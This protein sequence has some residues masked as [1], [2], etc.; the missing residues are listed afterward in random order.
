MRKK[1]NILF[2]CVGRR[3]E[4]LQAFIEAGQKLNIDLKIYGTDYSLT[5]PAL[6][7]CDERIQICRIS[8]K[9]YIPNL[10]NICK[11]KEIDLVIPTIDT[12]LLI[13]AQEKE[14]FLHINTK[15]LVSSVDKIKICRDKRDTAKFFIDC[16]LLTPVPVDDITNY[17]SGF[18]CFIKPLNGSSSINAYKV[19][20]NE[21]LL[22]YVT[23]VDDYII[24]PYIG[25]IEYTVDILCDFEGNPISITPRKRLE[26]RNGE[27]V[28]TQICNDQKIIEESKAII[29][30]FKPCGPITVQLIRERTTDND[31]YIEI[32]PRFGGGAPLS[33]KAGANSAEA[34]LRI[35]IN[36]DIDLEKLIAKE[37]LIFC[38]YDQSVCINYDEN[39]KRQ[40][41]AVIFDLDDTLYSE[42]Q[43]I[44]SGYKSVA[45][46][47]PE[48]NNLELKLWDAFLRGEK[49]IDYV[50]YKEGMFTEELK[51]KCLTIYRNHMPLINLYDGVEDML[52][53]L[54]SRGIKTGIITDGRHE[55][56]KAK[57]VALGLKELVDEIIITDDLGGVQF[58]KPNDIAFRVMQNR[59]NV[60]FENMIYVGDN[61][62]KDFIAPK[63]LGMD[64]Y[65]FKNK[66]GLYSGD[67]NNID[68]RQIFETIHQIS[69]DL[70]QHL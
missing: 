70:L 56:Q 53:D 41:K 52:L 69:D 33:M 12:D 36:D 29:N 58:R 15:V 27:V 63:K 62:N 14:K 26:V 66:D 6:Q 42:K 24:Q 50:L 19:F 30:K 38:R 22:R 21:D 17:L 55:G 47:I 16:G 37:K 7:F 28:K 5:A 10:L 9:D 1:V 65:Y 54:R 46:T 34:L 8:D 23:M 13:L 44:K 40:Y 25:G 60:P 35:L 59:L 2:T 48:I 31:Y 11:S 49:A 61:P 39:Y 32:N 43:Y 18:P 67:V 20:N 45:E 4:L 57:I 68:T 64:Y 51:E 3:V